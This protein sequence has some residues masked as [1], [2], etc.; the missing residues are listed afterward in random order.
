MVKN[1]TFIIELNNSNAVQRR[2][3]EN[4]N[5]AIDIKVNSRKE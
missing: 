1:V 5:S 3:K 2:E 4:I